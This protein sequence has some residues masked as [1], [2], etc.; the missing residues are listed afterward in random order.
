VTPCMFMPEYP[1]AGNLK[2]Q[3][4]KKIWNSPIF[5]ALRDRSYLKGKCQQCKFTIVCGGCRA[6]AVAYSG[7]YL[8]S[9]PTCPIE[10][11]TSPI[12]LSG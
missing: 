7:D 3:S 9:D 10:N 5:E 1:V 6:K 8:A 12:D 2:L 4:F 11:E